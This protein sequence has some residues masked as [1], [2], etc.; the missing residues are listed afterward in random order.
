MDVGEDGRG[1]MK[2]LMAVTDNDVRTVYIHYNPTDS[3][4]LKRYSSNLC[5]AQNTLSLARIQKTISATTLSMSLSILTSRHLFADMQISLSTDNFN[6]L[7]PTS[8]HL[9]KT[10]SLSL[11]SRR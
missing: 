10:L 11:N 9:P 4:L 6:L 8:P 5:N 1:L 3:R 2:S 7:S